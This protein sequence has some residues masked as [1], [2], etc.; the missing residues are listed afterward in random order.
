MKIS[1]NN[2]VSITGSY[3][4][5]IIIEYGSIMIFTEIYLPVSVD[6]DN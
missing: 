5:L 1:V 4:S 3:G 6:S 2:E